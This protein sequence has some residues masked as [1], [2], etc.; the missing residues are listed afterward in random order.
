MLVIIY[1]RLWRHDFQIIAHYEH[2]GNVEEYD[3]KNRE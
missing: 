1:Y 3:K 2:D